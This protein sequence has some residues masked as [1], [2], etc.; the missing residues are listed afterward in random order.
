MRDQGPFSFSKLSAFL[1]SFTLLNAGRSFLNAF[2]QKGMAMKGNNTTLYY[3]LNIRKQP[4]R[5][6]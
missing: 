6:S 3:I 1:I 5:H 4:Q 2:C